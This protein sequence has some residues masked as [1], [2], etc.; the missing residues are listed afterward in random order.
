MFPLFPKWDSAAVWHWAQRTHGAPLRRRCCQESG[1]IKGA[2][3]RTIKAP[4]SSCLVN[5]WVKRSLF[6]KLQYLFLFPVRRGR[7]KSQGAL[8]GHVSTLWQWRRGAERYCGRTRTLAVTQPNRKARHQ[9]NLT[10][11]LFTSHSFCISWH[12]SQFC[13]Y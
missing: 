10:Q 4:R 6:L 12:T 13:I 11:I 2:W 8:M 7:Q 1:E 5:K 3:R 9:A